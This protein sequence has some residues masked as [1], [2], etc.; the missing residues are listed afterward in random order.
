MSQA[1]ERQAYKSD[2]E[3]DA[4]A[5]LMLETCELMENKT[6]SI[7]DVRLV[8]KDV[9]I[10]LR[11]YEKEANNHW[12]L[13][14]GA[15]NHMTGCRSWF[16]ELDTSVSGSVRFGDGFEV[17]ISGRGSI[18]IE[19]RT[20]E[21]KVLTDVY[22]IPKLTNNI[23][24]LGQLK[25]RGCKV[26]LNRGKLRVFDRQGQLLFQVRRALNR[27]YTLDLELAQPVCLLAC[28]DDDAW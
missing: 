14:T 10:H 20:G 2:K 21:H 12:Y 13:D 1:E 6:E 25:E 8:E 5:P 16:T 28:L 9:Q 23:I 11:E 22:Y 17:T 15:S 27:L 7:E 19:G 24:S 3:D 4:P 26:V 18:L